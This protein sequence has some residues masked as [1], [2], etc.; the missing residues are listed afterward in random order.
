MFT[1]VTATVLTTTTTAPG[2][3]GAPSSPGA[4]SHAGP[5]GYIN[6]GDK[7]AMASAGAAQAAFRVASEDSWLVATANGGIWK[8][9]SLLAKRPH[10]TN[11]LDGQPVTC[12]S[13]SAMAGL[14]GTVVAGCGGA[15]SS[16]MGLNWQVFNS[17]DW[18]G[19]MASDDGGATWRMTSFPPNY[20]IT[21]V[22]VV[23]PR[24]FV[25]AARS[26]LHRA[27][28]GGVW[29]TADGG[30]TWTRT[31]ARPVYS[32]A[33]E[34]KSGVVLAAVPWSTTSV[35]LAS[36]SGGTAA[37][38]T[39]W[40]AGLGFDGRTPFYPTF[41]VGDGV[42]FYGALTVSPIDLTDT[43]SVVFSRPLSELAGGDASGGG[44][45]RVAN[46]PARLDIDGMP[47]DR[48]AL[49]VDPSDDSTL[50]VAGN[51]DALT[52]RV[53]WAAGAWADLGATDTTD[54]SEPHS[55]W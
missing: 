34:P 10:W 14:N 16:E 8:T 25:V 18:A 3:C 12:T 48:M 15:T 45:V 13:I 27:D 52:W 42:V 7:L 2:A 29:H 46:Q 38:W 33:R 28:D 41:A 22:V 49:L 1:F 51:A 37:D 4:W 19:V 5:G 6:E 40:E 53:D 55:D 54:G 20:F 32:L 30:A 11:V 23:G 9:A 39:A 21:S 36:A 43:A 31:F 47:K 26:H 17:G 44:W 24:S 35:V 50:Y